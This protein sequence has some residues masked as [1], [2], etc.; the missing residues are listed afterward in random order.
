LQLQ[1][2]SRSP[3][4]VH[5]VNAFA[6]TAPDQPAA[7]VDLPDPQPTEGGVR[8]R[9][10]AAS[11][12]GFD[13]FEAS[14]GLAAMMP[15]EL[16]TVVGRDF[17]GVVDGL[18]D[19]RSDFAVGD[20]VF[21]FIPSTPPLHDGTFAEYVVRGRDLVLARK[22]GPLSFPVAAAIPLAGGT[23]LDSVDAVAPG[24]GD[25]V[26]VIGA[27][28]GVGSVALQ[29]AVQRGATIIATAKAGDEEAFIREIGASDTIYY[30]ADDVV[31]AMRARYPA[32]VTVLIDTVSRGE[33]FGRV[34]ELLVEG[35]RVATTLGAADVDALAARNV[36]A[37]NVVGRPTPER[38]ADLADQVVERSLTI[39]IQRTFPL[40]QAASALEAFS[41]GT[42]GK[43]VL[44]I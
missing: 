17:A 7:L 39:R 25:A 13:V 8:I 40:A 27:T 30:A 32:G 9:V 34:V 33:A 31:D 43:I 26:L 23:A 15:H 2:P 44:E 24:L 19:G 29:L 11:V 21:G 28:G 4:D 3:E 38:I 12:N 20:E 14:G 5:A 36:Q 10:R 6:L 41:G 42:L 16:P 18:G 1:L 37:T 35:G 22:P